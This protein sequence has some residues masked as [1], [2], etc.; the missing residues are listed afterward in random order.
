[1]GFLVDWQ[2]DPLTYWHDSAITYSLA[3]LRV[4]DVRANLL[5]ASNVF[6]QAA[7]DKYTFL[8][9]AYLQRRRYLIY[10]GNLP[11]DQDNKTSPDTGDTTVSP[12][13]RFTPNWPVFRR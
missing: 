10:D 1:V 12:Y 8:R 2:M 6:E 13:H 3:A 4:V 5:G 9:D 7:V 11:E